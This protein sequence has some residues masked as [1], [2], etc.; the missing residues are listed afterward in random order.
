[1]RDLNSYFDCQSYC[2]HLRDEFESKLNF[3]EQIDVS[4]KIR[5]SLANSNHLDK[6]N[7]PYALKLTGKKDYLI[8][9]I[10]HTINAI[11]DLKLQDKINWL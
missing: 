4:T 2:K 7:Y 1:M 9:W 11:Y 10:E 8:L 6:I 3:H 5:H